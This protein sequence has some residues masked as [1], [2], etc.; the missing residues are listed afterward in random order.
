MTS[1][2]SILAVLLVAGGLSAMWSSSGCAQSTAEYV[3]QFDATWSA[4]T[5]PLNFPPNPHFS[6]LIGGTHNDQ[7]AFWE[8]GEL[9]ISSGSVFRGY[10]AEGRDSVHSPRDGEHRT[11][12]LVRRDS[13]GRYHF[14]SRKDEMMKV[15]GLK[16]FPAEIERVLRNHP[17]VITNPLRFPQPIPNTNTRKIPAESQVITNAGIAPASALPS[18]S[19]Q[20]LI[21]VARSALRLPES[22]SSTMLK[23]AT[24][25]SIMI[26]IR[27][28]KKLN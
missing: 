9:A 4:Q 23:V 3:V 6:G 21:G 20:V 8:V 22:F 11:G 25:I 2:R 5:H 10:L 15:A 24:L 13:L 26:G 17:A 14:A 28:R 27:S 7:V 18:R 16:V 19:Y 1:Q 12:D